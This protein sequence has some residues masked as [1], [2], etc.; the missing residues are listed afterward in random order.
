MIHSWSVVGVSEFHRVRPTLLRNSIPITAS[1]LELNCFCKCLEIKSTPHV[2]PYNENEL[3][4]VVHLIMFAVQFFRMYVYTLS[5]SCAD[6]ESNRN[7]FLSKLPSSVVGCYLCVST[8]LSS[9]VYWFTS[10]CD[11]RCSFLSLFIS[12]CVIVRIKKAQ[13][14]DKNSHAQKFTFAVDLFVVVSS[15]YGYLL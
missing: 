1:H 2:Q 15:Y 6:A 10:C 5:L 3:V 8:R 7:I 12:H 13:I 14:L 11:M 9:A 4:A